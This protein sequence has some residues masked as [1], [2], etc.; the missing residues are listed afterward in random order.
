[1][2]RRFGVR[3]AAGAPAATGSSAGAAAARAAPGAAAL[4]GAGIL[5]RF[6]GAAT[7]SVLTSSSCL[8]ARSPLPASAGRTAVAR[9]F[10][11]AMPASD[12]A[13]HRV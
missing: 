3:G 1:V 5:F 13:R 11:A 4:A 10:F 12:I 7:G 8:A 2:A 9:A 6:P